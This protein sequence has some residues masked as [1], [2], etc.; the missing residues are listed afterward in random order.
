MFREA[1]NIAESFHNDTL[2][3]R[4]NN[5]IGNYFIERDN[6]PLAYKYFSEAK[7][8]GD[9]LNNE[10]LSGNATNGIGLVKLNLNDFDLAIENF[11]YAYRIYYK[12]KI[13]RDEAGCLMNLGICYARKDS[14]NK[15]LNYHEKTLEILKKNQ[16][17]IILCKAL[18]NIG[19]IADQR[20]NDTSSLSYLFQALKIAQ[21]INN[22]RL[23]G[24]VTLNIGGH[25][26]AKKQFEQA[27][28]YLIK[29][30]RILSEIRFRKAIMNANLLLSDISGHNNKWKDAYIY[31]TEY[32]KIK[33]SILNTDTQKKI[34][35]YQFEM[36]LQKKQLEKTLLSRKLKIQQKNMLILGLSI[37]SIIIIALIIGRNLKKSIA[38]QKQSNKY[39]NEKILLA[40]KIKKLETSK[41]LSEIETKNNELVGFSLKL[42]TKND[43]LNEISRLSKKYYDKA[44]LDKSFFNDLTKIINDNRNLDKEWRQFKLLFEQVHNN[45]FNTLKYKYPNLTE[46]D[47]RFCSYLKTNLSTK[48]ISRLLNISPDTVRK[49][50]YRLKKKLNLTDLSVEDFLRNI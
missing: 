4:I 36:E 23:I 28:K 43:L 14:I 47:L 13:Y 48:E 32:E 44:S 35:D 20:Q 42:I 2:I 39:L 17:S 45:F 9:K 38:L 22:R 37:V 25:F 7:Q 41:H 8:I 3:S 5:S 34:S 27:E 21:L 30:H 18:V 12:N 49:S 15:A 29:S 50:K 11:E 10:I 40:E 16:D 46:H 6:Y 24:L 19:L 33:D 1:L 26:Y 31:Y